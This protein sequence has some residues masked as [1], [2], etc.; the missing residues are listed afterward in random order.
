VGVWHHSGEKVFN[1]FTN[2]LDLSAKK[3]RGQNRET[4]SSLE[5]LYSSGTE[6]N[7]IGQDLRVTS[8]FEDRI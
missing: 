2:V 4:D 8:R 1:Q 5:L 7:V 6:R 3:R